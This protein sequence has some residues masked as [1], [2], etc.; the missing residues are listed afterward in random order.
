[1]LFLRSETRA[2]SMNLVYL[3]TLIC[4]KSNLISFQIQAAYSQEIQVSLKLKE[5]WFDREGFKTRSIENSR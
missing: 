2:K 1:M 5:I 3:K 4:L